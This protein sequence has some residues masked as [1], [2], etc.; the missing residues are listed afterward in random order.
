MDTKLV[1][2][3]LDTK[4][5]DTRVTVGSGNVFADIGLPNP[6][7]ALAKAKLLVA[8]TRSISEAGIDHSGAAKIL[9]VAPLILELLLRGQTEEFSIERLIR[10][11]HTMGRQVEIT[12]LP[13]VA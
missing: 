8:L 5:A 13:K 2:R 12:L 4:I 3:E 9:G 1:D 11:I 7:E 10:M 6:E